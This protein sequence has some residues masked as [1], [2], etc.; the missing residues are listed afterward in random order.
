MD[1]IIFFIIG[2]Y[3]GD[4]GLQTDRMATKKKESIKYLTYHVLTYTATIVI[5]FL[6]YIWLENIRYLP[7]LSLLIGLIV[8]LFVTHWAQDFVKSRMGPSR[9]LYYI[10]QSLHLL[11]LM[12]FRYIIVGI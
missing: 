11:L 7:P 1:L 8:I 5:S 10:D 6:L 3:I 9:Q 2:H 12:V 4:Y